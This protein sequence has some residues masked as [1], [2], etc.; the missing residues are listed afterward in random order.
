MAINV[1]QHAINRYRE[2]LCDYTSST[3]NIRKK[4]KEA[5]SLGKLIANK[6]ASQG[7]CF[8]RIYND[9]SVIVIIDNNDDRAT[10]VTCLGDT[11]YRK[12]IKCQNPYIVNGRVM[13][14]L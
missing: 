9:I 10:V 6:P 7:N 13:H 14:G 12:W 1:T 11:A 5:A 4:L 8:E 2:R 3:K